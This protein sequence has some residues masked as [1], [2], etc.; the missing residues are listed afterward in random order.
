[1][2]LLLQPVTSIITEE[3]IQSTDNPMIVYEDPLVLNQTRLLS[4]MVA[5]QT[6][7]GGRGEFA[8]FEILGFNDI[9]QGLLGGTADT[10]ESG[11]T[12]GAP[13]A[14]DERRAG[15]RSTPSCKR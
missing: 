13:A 8:A 15:R 3:T 12:G 6:I 1:V 5:D 9:G 14:D 10:G 4:E 2:E 7:G 11:A